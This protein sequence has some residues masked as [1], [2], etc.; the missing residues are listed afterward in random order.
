MNI[1][2]IFATILINT[3]AI[4]FHYSQP[5][6]QFSGQELKSNIKV[7]IQNLLSNSNCQQF[8]KAIFQNE[9]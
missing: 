6:L 8:L 3:E 9:S 7:S 4:T 2:L 5:E 1:S